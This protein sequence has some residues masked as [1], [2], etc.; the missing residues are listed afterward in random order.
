MLYCT[1]FAADGESKG[2]QDGRPVC[3]SCLADPS[4]IPAQAGIQWGFRRLSHDIHKIG[5]WA[6]REEVSRRGAKLAE[7]LMPGIV[8]DFLLIAAIPLC[9]IRGE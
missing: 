3:R 7:I 6:R 1:L 9:V 4:V 8:S 5:Y 2:S